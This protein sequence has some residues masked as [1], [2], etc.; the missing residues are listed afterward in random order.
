MSQVRYVGN[1]P[2]RLDEF[3][4]ERSVRIGR[5]CDMTAQ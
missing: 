5:D 1:L 2:Q 4:V 3:Q